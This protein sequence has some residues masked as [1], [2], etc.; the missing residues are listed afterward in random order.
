MSA[1]YL[2]GQAGVLSG[3]VTLSVIP[4]VGCQ[5]PEN[6]VE[7]AGELAA[8][9][10]GYVWAMVAG[11]LLK[12]KDNR[13]T[14]YSTATGEPQLYSEL[15]NLPKGLTTKPRPSLAYSWSGGEW[16]IDSALVA[17]L[18]EEAQAVAW[19]NIKAER[20]RRKEAGFKVGDSWVHSDL[21]SRSQWLGLKDNARDALAAGGTMGGVLRDSDGQV[22][23]WKMLD[24]AFAEVT[25]QLAFDV[26]ASVTRSDMAIFKAAETHSA[27]MRAAADPS[28]YD[29]TDGWPE[30]YAE[31]VKILPVEPETIPPVE[32]DP[33]P[34]QEPEPEAPA[35]PDP[36]SLPDTEE[37][38]AQ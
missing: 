34:A 27:H 17:Q 36:E 25:A 7:L 3:P 2:I 28:A 18:K 19:E 1:I 33:V 24:G 35:D 10:D 13:G 37:E 38:A 29:F 5:M 30:T 23:I 31:S 15:G 14:V 32:P 20:D 4:G 22:I 9:P 21:F 16:K 11:A 6:A 26:V 12:T 8:A